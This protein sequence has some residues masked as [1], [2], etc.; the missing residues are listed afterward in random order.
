LISSVM[1]VTI[2]WIEAEAAEAMVFAATC[3]HLAVFLIAWHAAS[4]PD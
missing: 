4:M 3:Q 1:A 2:V